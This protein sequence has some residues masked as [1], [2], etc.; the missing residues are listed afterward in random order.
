MSG[1]TQRY[2]TQY[3][4]ESHEYTAGSSECDEILQISFVSEDVLCRDLQLANYAPTMAVLADIAALEA[5]S[6]NV[7]VGIPEFQGVWGDYIGINHNDNFSTYEEEV[8]LSGNFVADVSNPGH[9]CLS[10]TGQTLFDELLALTPPACLGSQDR[11]ALI[12]ACVFASANPNYTVTLL[13]PQ[14][15]LLKTTDLWKSLRSRFENLRVF[16]PGILIKIILDSSYGVMP[17]TAS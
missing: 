4:R 10:D 3:Y 1:N 8:F 9:Y 16:D 14:A 7:S 5:D 12:T 13:A 2:Q 15:D 6:W 11:A 17:R